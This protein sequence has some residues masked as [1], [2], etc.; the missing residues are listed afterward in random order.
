VSGSLIAAAALG[1]ALAGGVLGFD[2]WPHVN[3]AAGD[4]ALAIAAP[5][6]QPLRAISLAHGPRAAARA[7]RR[8]A[9]VAA[10]VR[11]RAVASPAPARRAP[12]SRRR[13][14]TTAPSSS[15]PVAAP[16]P[17]SAPTP[18]PLP[19]PV[20]S[21]PQTISQVVPAPPPAPLAPAADVVEQTTGT[22]G[23][24][25]VSTTGVV[26]T[27][28]SVVPGAGRALGRIGQAAAD[29]VQSTGV[30]VGEIVRGLAHAKKHG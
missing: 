19:A 13:V 26:S 9:A 2:S 20:S 12:S 22:V 27:A 8:A 10:P 14:V 11:R 23:K 29:L 30:T 28:V 3:P 16:A 7:P 24:T 21:V 25:V 5:A 1:L 18:V 17:T 4:S 15:A 6:A